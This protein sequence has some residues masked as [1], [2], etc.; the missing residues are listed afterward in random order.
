MNGRPDEAVAR[1][2]DVFRLAQSI[3]S[4]GVAM[5]AFEGWAAE[6]RAVAG[7]W[8]LRERLTP[9]ETRRLLNRL[10]RLDA[11]REPLETLHRREEAWEQHAMGALFQMI[12]Y[13]AEDDRLLTGHWEEVAQ[14][15]L[16]SQAW[17]RILICELAVRLYAMDRGS[18]PSTLAALVPDY[19]PQLP[20]DPFTG[21]PLKYLRRG[22][23]HLIYSIGPDRKDDGGKLIESG[24]SG[25]VLVE[26]VW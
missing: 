8:Q 14:R 1:V 10:R 11:E 13:L 24:R 26:E 23:G 9:D 21:E 6:D 16:R 22:S 2:L 12:T 18:E 25:D 7:L 3:A 17:M 19:L 4:E 20:A 5:D 15:G